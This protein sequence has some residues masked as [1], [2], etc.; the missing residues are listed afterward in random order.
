VRTS[1]KDESCT[2]LCLSLAVFAEASDDIEVN[3]SADY[4]NIDAQ[5]GP[6]AL[7]TPRNPAADTAYDTQVIFPETGVHLYNPAYVTGDPFTTYANYND[8]ID[9]RRW[10]MDQT[11]D[12]WSASGRLDWDITEALHIK[13]IAAYRTYDLS[14][15][16]D[17]DYTPFDLNTTYNLQNHQQTSLELQLSGSLF[18]NKVSWKSR[19]FSE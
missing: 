13:T 14:W 4:T 11:T 10:P 6:T 18:S 3:L 9:G 7:L 5:P 19:G 16:S 17:Q 2:A 12:A 15:A 8:P 1:F